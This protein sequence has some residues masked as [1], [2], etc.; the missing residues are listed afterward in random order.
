MSA[1][2]YAI[3]FLGIVLELCLVWRLLSNGL[4]RE[5]S[6]F[7]IYVLFVVLR[8]LGLFGV[9]NV[10]P[11]FFRD[12]YWESE[13]VS[14]TLRFLV[15]WE[16][17]RHAF[18]RGITLADSTAKGYLVAASGL[19][20]IPAVMLWSVDSYTASFSVRLALERSFGYVQA[21]L[22]LEILFAARYCGIELGRN[23]SGIA[24]AFGG[25]LSVS[26]AN[27]AMIA[28]HHSYLPYWQVLGPTAFLL[29]LSVWIW[30]VWVSVPDPAFTEDGSAGTGSDLRFWEDNWGR[31]I[32][33]VRRIVRS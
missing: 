6:Y 14:M 25:N 8:T 20:L 12:L 33:S 26:T 13:S 16:V 1:P 29:M 18:P 10:A 7:L 28:M 15:I 17:Y 9:M 32:S 23:L 24:V 21:V 22:L 4:W 11:A 19:L 5:Y 2:S 3:L 31:T 30:A 27:D